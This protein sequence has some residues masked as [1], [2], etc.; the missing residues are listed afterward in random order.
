M[1]D[2]PKPPTPLGSPPHELGSPSSMPD[3]MRIKLPTVV[4]YHAS[5]ST[6][7]ALERFL[8]R[9]YSRS[10]A[11][12]EP[13]LGQKWWKIGFILVCS[14][15]I[16]GAPLLKTS[17]SQAK[18]GLKTHLKL[19]VVVRVRSSSWFDDKYYTTNLAPELIVQLGTNFQQLAVKNAQKRL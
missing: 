17:P 16:F 9:F 19:R 15:V 14:E 1:I 2:H 11:V 18:I 13:F 8:S 6:S 10:S 4:H 12:S 3:P 7:R 5:R